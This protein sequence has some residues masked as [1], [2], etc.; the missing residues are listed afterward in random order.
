MPIRMVR[1]SLGRVFTGLI[2]YDSSH[3]DPGRYG[4]KRIDDKSPQSAGNPIPLKRPRVHAPT[5]RGALIFEPHTWLIT[6]AVGRGWQSGE[7]VRRLPC[8]KLPA[9]MPPRLHFMPGPVPSE[10][11]A[12]SRPPLAAK[13]FF[14]QQLAFMN[15]IVVRSAKGGTPNTNDSPQSSSGDREVKIG[16]SALAWR[17]GYRMLAVSCRTKFFALREFPN[18]C[19]WW[20]VAK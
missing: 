1:L 2:R 4:P 17:G 9:R 6:L 3:P 5:D 12:A 18:H 16:T 19:I 14:A 20:P 15:T 8:G 13:G 10:E 7:S 11:E